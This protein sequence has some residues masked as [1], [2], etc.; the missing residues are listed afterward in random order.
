LK[1]GVS[2]TEYRDAFRTALEKQADRCRPELV[3]ISAGFDAHTDD[4]IGSLGLESEDFALLTQD[5]LDVAKQRAGGRVISL[6]E[7]GYDLDALAESVE[8]H[9]AGLLEESA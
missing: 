1:F 5:V 3:L 8:I 7:G 6:L 2:R 4:P 9:L